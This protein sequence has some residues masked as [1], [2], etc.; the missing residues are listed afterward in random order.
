MVFFNPEILSDTG[1]N[2]EEIFISCIFQIENVV[3]LSDLYLLQ[4]TMDLKSLCS[5]LI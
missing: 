2:N 3:Y 1:L 4:N 5:V